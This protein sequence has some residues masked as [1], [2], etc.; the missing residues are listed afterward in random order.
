MCPCG[1]DVWRV[2]GYR[3]PDG[4]EFDDPLEIEC[5]RCHTIRRLIDREQDGYDGEIAGGARGRL[6]GPKDLWT[7]SRCD[8]ADGHLMASFGYQ[9]EPFDPDEP[10][11]SRAQDF[12]DAFLLRHGCLL[13]NGIAE[14]VTLECA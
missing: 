9:F 8:S 11:A 6:T 12:F 3:I 4:T 14:V 10:E 7:C 2:Y 5:C 1:N 13:G